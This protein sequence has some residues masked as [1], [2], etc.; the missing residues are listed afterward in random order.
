MLKN[1]YHRVLG[2]ASHPKAEL[3]LF[4]VAF[5]ESS[6]FPIPPDILL[7][8]MVLVAFD[9][10]F[11]Y[12]FVCTLGSVL[13]GI[14]GYVIGHFFF[15]ALGQP[16]VDMY[17]L[18]DKLEV[19]RTWYA[20]YDVFIVGAAGFS[21]IPYKVFTIFSG[22]MQADFMQFVLA[23]I[24]SRGARFFLIAWLLWRGGAR[25]KNW[26]ETNFY[27]L[28]MAGTVALILLFVLGKLLWINA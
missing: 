4:T 22:M 23:S 5:I 20:E 10:A 16:L 26:I 21:P 6:F 28:T 24:L 12:A 1:L 11:R 17:H 15:D 3:A 9:K 13:G 8:P 14:F 25:F 19:L 7:I 27:V 18:A 2:Y